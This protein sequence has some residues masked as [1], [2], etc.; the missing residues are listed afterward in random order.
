MNDDR[1]G[2]VSP[3]DIVASLV[4]AVFS[5][6]IS[7]RITSFNQGAERLTGLRCAEALGSFCHEVLRCSLCRQRCP[8][9]TV[10]A[11][12]S[13]MLIGGAVMVN[14]QGN[15]VAVSVSAAL[16]RN[17]NNEI[18]GGVEMFQDLR[19]LAD[20]PNSMEGALRDFE[21]QTILA[22]LQRNNNNRT[23]TAE[24][25]GIH[26]STFFR[27][28]KSLGID[29]PRQDGR[30]RSC[31]ARADQPRVGLQ[32]CNSPSGGLLQSRNNSL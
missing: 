29:L 1:G 25:L 18:V 21:C 3:T 14:S 4:E 28:I 17:G 13:P 9:Q 31:S 32:G 16:L 8:L 5:V 22:A 19:L 10:F 20:R 6:D 23:A 7:W 11:S 2:L 12:G 26:K 15:Q 27:K 30:F 24:E